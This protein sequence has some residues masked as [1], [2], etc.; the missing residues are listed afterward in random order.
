MFCLLGVK[1]KATDEL[2]VVQVNKKAIVLVKEF[3]VVVINFI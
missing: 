1:R 2:E 3:V